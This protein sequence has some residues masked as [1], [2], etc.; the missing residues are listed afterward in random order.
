MQNEMT[1][2]LPL[3]PHRRMLISSLTAI[4]VLAAIALD[5]KVVRIGSEEDVREQSFSPEAFA[6]RTFPEIQS[7]VLENAVPA[8]EVLE[9]I[10][11]DKKAA[12]ERYGVAAGVGPVIPVSFRG[13]VG[14]G[15]SGIYSIF[16]EGW[17]EGYQLRVQTGPAING[18][19][20]RDATGSIKFGQ[21]TN[22][23]EYQ[24]A[25]AALN[26][27]MKSAV[28]DTIDTSG[29]SGKSVRVVGVFKLINPKN[30]L[31]TPVRLELK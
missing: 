3:K 22:Q 19:D 6:K 5:T 17:P 18:T 26:R 1:L 11:Q 16:V 14:N 29:L 2:R 31:V 7:F 20:L 30:W 21:F 8:R 13:V 9:A 28:L 24:D 12:A 10:E 15:K 27:A 23:I 25:G 4:L